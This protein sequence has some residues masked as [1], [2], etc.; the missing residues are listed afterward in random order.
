MTKYKLHKYLMYS[1]NHEYTHLCNK[2]YDISSGR[3][4]SKLHF[5]FPTVDGYSVHFIDHNLNKLDLTENFMIEY[6]QDAELKGKDHH[7]LIEYVEEKN[8]IFGIDSI[9]TKNIIICK[10][11]NE[12]NQNICG[13][14]N[15]CQH[16]RWLDWNYSNEIFC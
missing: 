5:N 11:Y 6:V 1:R 3:R 13:Y 8:H 9:S 14:C 16:S 2:F 12:S 4:C 7:I 15:L 10:N